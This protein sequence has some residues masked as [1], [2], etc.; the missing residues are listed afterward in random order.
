MSAVQSTTDRGRRPA[1][2]G[3]DFIPEDGE[4]ARVILEV[5][6]AATP[7]GDPTE[8]SSSLRMMIRLLVANRFPMLLWWGPEYIQIYN[9][10]YAPI[11]GAKHPWAMGVPTRQC[12][13]E[14]WDVLKPMIDTPFN[15]GPATWL[16]DF[17]VEINR[18]GFIEESHFTV[19]YSPVPDDTAP[20]GIGGVLA[21]VHE[22]SEKVIGERRVRILRELGS[23]VAEAKTDREACAMATSI[24]AQYPKDV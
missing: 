2:A 8:W 24:F 18:H 1:N 11:L 23:R 12:W 14:I 19:A 22:I 10:A 16:E 13:S 20:R 4:A 6:W 5:D 15:G 21:T 9:D 3:V 17:E 7:L